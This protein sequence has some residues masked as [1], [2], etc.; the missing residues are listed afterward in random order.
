[1]RFQKHTNNS[2]LFLHEFCVCNP[3]K[4]LTRQNSSSRG[5]LDVSRLVARAKCNRDSYESELG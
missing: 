1:M 3:L 2:F 5:N 4:I